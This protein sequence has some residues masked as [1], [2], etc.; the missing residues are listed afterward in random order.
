MS[1]REKALSLL[2]DIGYLSKNYLARVLKTT[3]KEAGSVLESLT[4]QQDTISFYISCKDRQIT[5]SNKKVPGSTINA[6]GL[7]SKANEFYK[8]EIELKNKIYESSELVYPPA[9][10]GVFL[11]EKRKLVFMDKVVTS[12]PVVSNFNSDKKKLV[13]DVKPVVKH[14]ERQQGLGMFV[15]HKVSDKAAEV[16]SVKVEEKEKSDEII[17]PNAVTPKVEVKLEPMEICENSIEAEIKDTEMTQVKSEVVKKVKKIQNVPQNMKKTS[18]FQ[19]DSSPDKLKK[20][21]FSDLLAN[22]SLYTE[23]EETE[24]SPAKSI[25]P[26][27][28]PQK[29]SNP[30]LPSHAK[31]TNQASLVPNPTKIKKKVV[32]TR[33]FMQGNKLVTEDYTSEEE[34]TINPLPFALGKNKGVQQLIFK[35]V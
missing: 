4:P 32:K 12:A 2:L 31:P 16:V 28:L 3:L 21:A 8:I 35:Y 20:N 10:T 33:S 23:E 1:E 17:K 7:K 15:K 11:Q 13:Q 27:K 5:L 34:I 6:I 26:V 22:K 14:A 30:S 24:S 25:T 18:K 19:E 29:R 9:D